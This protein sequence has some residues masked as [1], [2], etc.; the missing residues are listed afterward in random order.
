[1]QPRP[2][3]RERLIRYIDF[4]EDELSHFGK[5]AMVS[6]KKYQEDRG[7]M[8]EGVGKKI[9][10]QDTKTPRKAGNG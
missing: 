3:E 7:R 9:H 2:E 8:A 6:W 1:M 4:L 5:F 10:H